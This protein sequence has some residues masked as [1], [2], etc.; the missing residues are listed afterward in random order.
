M[1]KPTYEQ[2]EQ[3]ILK[4]QKTIQNLEAKVAQLE[5]KLNRN[6]RN[7]SRPPSTDQK[8]NIPKSHSI[9]KQGPYHP[10]ANRQLLPEQMVTTREK[11]ELTVCPRC[12]STMQPTGSSTKWQQVDLP[13]IKPLV[14]EIE[15]CTCQ[16]TRCGLTQTPE[17]VHHET[18]MMGPRLEGFVNLLMAKF[19]QSHLTVRS[20][21]SMLIPGLCLSQ[22]LVAKTKQRGVQAFA[23][24]AEELTDEIFKAEGAKFMD[25]TG[26]RHMGKNWQAL[27][28]RSPVIVRYF[29]RD[30]QNGTT[31]AAI[32]PQEVDHL[33]TDRGLATQK[34]K[35]KH[36]QYCLAHFS[37]NIQGMAE[38]PN[39][40]N[41]ETQALGEIH[42]TLQALFH[43]KHRCERSEID[44]ATWKQYGYRKWAWM[45]EKF[46]DL[47]RTTASHSLR[48]FCKRVLKDWKHFMVYLAR[49][50]PM[51][52]NLAEEGLR[53]LVIARKLCFGSRSSYGLQWRETVH[54]CVETLHRQG[55]SMMDFFA[56]TIRAFRTGEPCPRIV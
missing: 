7:S 31:V 48:R 30:N 34:V 14:H 11:R 56:D 13:S 53:N 27:L 41:D 42:E 51:T 35:V 8:E 52:N 21:I 46:E 38:D 47:Y 12:R 23:Q 32:L 54:S 22:G 15:L 18:L 49:N 19:R 4:L 29:L 44:V 28:V 2:L 6:S 26:W 45:R 10:G 24:A 20:F 16:C 55:K 50:G 25:A 37:R 3:T 43:E 39:T 17:L 1:E 40:S 5:A 9:E 36:L 33:V